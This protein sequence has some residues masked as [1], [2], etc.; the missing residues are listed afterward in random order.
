MIIG[1][2]KE[3]TNNELRVGI[4]PENANEYIQN[5][6]QVF[7]E[8][9]AGLGS[10]FTDESYLSYGAHIL[11]SA[12]QVWEKSEMIIKVKE[13]LTQ[14]FDLLQEGQIL[15]AYLHL[16]ANQAAAKALIDKKVTAVAYETLE[17]QNG[18]LPLLKPMSEIAGRLSIQI[19]ARF[20]EAPMGGM[21]ILLGGV[22]GVK[23]AN[24]VIIGAGV[25]GS[26]ACKAA[27][28]FGA[29]VTVMDKN[30]NKLA[31]LDDL[32]GSKIQ[33]QHSSDTAIEQVLQGADL[34]ICSALRVGASAP[35]L[36]KRSYLSSMKKGSVIVDIAIDQGGCAETSRPTT[37]A[38][39]TYVVDDVIHYC[40]TNMPGA[41]PMTSTLALTNATLDTG[42]RI[43]AR[44][45][46]NALRRY[47]LLATGINTYQG[48]MTNAALAKQYQLPYHDVL[49]LIS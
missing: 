7:M 30:L 46:E 1:C 24:I 36:I 29:V 4:T 35:K 49:E 21:G 13:P 6:H 44:G 20:L 45:L 34:I 43:G 31:Y 48:H 15:Y 33:T 27:I 9:G 5:G 38:N 2:V 14:E 40:V 37:H 39:P 42:L 41:V 12:L 16:A 26:N 28:N 3:L 11:P 10:G 22:T 17:D 32:Y 8:T 23:K 18:N 25:A 47:P 19:G